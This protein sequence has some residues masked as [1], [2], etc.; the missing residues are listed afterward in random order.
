[1]PLL[2]QAQPQP[3]LIDRKQID[4]R[5][6]LRVTGVS[7]K[8]GEMRELGGL[9]MKGEVERGVI[10]VAESKDT[11]YWHDDGRHDDGGRKTKEGSAG[12]LWKLVGG[13]HDVF[14]GT[15]FAW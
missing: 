6:F 1:M 11:R 4:A 7:S 9:G 15:C 10:I 8:I 12:C 13:R 14:Q 3:E 2:S 5:R